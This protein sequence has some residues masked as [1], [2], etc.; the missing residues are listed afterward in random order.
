MA[1]VR[2]SLIRTCQHFRNHINSG[3][4]VA[5]WSL[6]QFAWWYPS[7]GIRVGINT[8]GIT[9]PIPGW[10]SRHFLALAMTVLL[11]IA[12]SLFDFRGRYCKFLP[13]LCLKEALGLPSLLYP[14]CPPSARSWASFH[15]ITRAHHSHDSYCEVFGCMPH[16]TV[17]E[18]NGP[19][20]NIWKWM[21]CVADG[22]RM[23]GIGDGRVGESLH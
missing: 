5:S 1:F 4:T 15:I 11:L 13:R 10:L 3:T 20:K 9:F 14:H 21:D 7:W 17:R 19:L 8:T 2:R 18:N 23:L 22:V 6:R 12:M 16:T